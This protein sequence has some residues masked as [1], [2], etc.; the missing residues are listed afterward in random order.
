MN[1]IYWCYNRYD[2]YGVYV[3]ATNRNK[4]RLYAIGDIDCDYIDINANCKA[5]NVNLAEGTTMDCSDTDLIIK[6]GLTVGCNFCDF[7][8]TCD[9][10][11]KQHFYE[12]EDNNG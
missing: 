7:S 3:V 11:T 12:S 9:Y 10:E 1:N 5:K 6:Y 4:A 2:F 8:S